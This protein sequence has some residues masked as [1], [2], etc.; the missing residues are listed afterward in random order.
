MALSWPARNLPLMHQV[1]MVIPTIHC[2]V[3]EDG[4]TS[5]ECVCVC[6][7]ACAACYISM[8]QVWHVLHVH[9]P[10][11]VCYFVTLTYPCID[12]EMRK[13]IPVMKAVVI[14]KERVCLVQIS[15]S[16]SLERE[17]V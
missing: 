17:D 12:V 4:A 5:S 13:V 10:N 3:E 15:L 1:A 14:E 2:M 8:Q 7:C 11:G 6:V 9:G 16:Q